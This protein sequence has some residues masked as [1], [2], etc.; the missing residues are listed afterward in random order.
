MP[1]KNESDSKTRKRTAT[2][3]ENKKDESQKSEDPSMEENMTELNEG[4]KTIFD[5]LDSISQKRYMGLYTIVYNICT[6]SDRNCQQDSAP[7]GGQSNSLDP[8]SNQQSLAGF[9]LYQKLSA[10]LETQVRGVHKQTQTTIL[11]GGIGQDDNTLEG[12]ETILRE[13]VRKIGKKS[14]FLHR[15][16]SCASTQI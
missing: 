15:S 14:K 11:S 6:K 8:T 12:D 5:Q 16:D 10:F 2:A 7:I 4:L 1:N 9:E 13:R 3:N